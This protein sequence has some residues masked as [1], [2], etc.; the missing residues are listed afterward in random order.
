MATIKH[1]NVN[2]PPAASSPEGQYFVKRPD[3]PDRFDVY[4]VS[5][6]TVKKQENN[7]ETIAQIGRDTPVINVDKDYPLPSGFYTLT[8]AISEIPTDRRKQGLIITYL[9]DADTSETIQFNSNDVNKFLDETVWKKIGSGTKVITQ[10]HEDIGYVEYRYTDL[11]DYYVDT[12]GINLNMNTG[13]Q[14]TSNPQNKTAFLFKVPIPAN[15]PTTIKAALDQKVNGSANNKRV[16]IYDDT[17]LIQTIEA[18]T[19]V[20]NEITFQF[21]IPVYFSMYI[22]YEDA[23]GYKYNNKLD[24]RL[25]T[26]GDIHKYSV[27]LPRTGTIDLKETDKKIDDLVKGIYQHGEVKKTLIPMTT[28]TDRNSNYYGQVFTTAGYTM[29][30][31]KIEAGKRYELVIGKK[32][33]GSINAAKSSTTGIIGLLPCAGLE[34]ISFKVTNPVAN[35]LTLN[36]INPQT[37]V[38][39]AY[40]ISNTVA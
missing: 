23:L 33:R 15:A 36:I 21:D 6:R 32:L 34:R 31:W 8:S 24:F 4:I 5:N 7:E 26:K 27:E 28:S 2:T 10:S 14:G 1:Y 20:N 30:Q 37:N 38:I 3:N 17:S 40:D 29:G 25:Y 13:N 11:L 18:A 12:P 19:A 9:I 39:D 35:L 16:L 22:D